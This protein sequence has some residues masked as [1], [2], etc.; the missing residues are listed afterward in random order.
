MMTCVFQERRVTAVSIEVKKSEHKYVTGP[1]GHA[2]QEIFAST[3]VSVEMPPL[4]SDTEVI[5]LRGEPDRLAT[6]LI[7]VYDRAN[8]RSNTERISLAPSFGQ[9]GHSISAGLNNSSQK[10]DQPEGNRY[11]TLSGADMPPSQTY[12]PRRSSSACT[13]EATIKNGANEIMD[14][15]TE[16]SDR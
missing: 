7:Q 3:G 2:L 12:D 13:R 10:Q 9:W 1:K 4:D 6:A 5:T 14:K 15:A 11:S 8:R 16:V